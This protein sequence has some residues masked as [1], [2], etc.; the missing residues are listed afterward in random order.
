MRSSSRGRSGNPKGRPKKSATQE[1]ALQRVLAQQIPIVIDRKRKL[2][3]ADEAILHR[4]LIK[5]L[6][7]DLRAIKLF[8]DI[9]A[10]APPRDEQTDQIEEMSPD[11]DAVIARYL[12]RRRRDGWSPAGGADEQGGEDE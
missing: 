9:R 8:N 1:T 3:A 2:M 12:G 11:D 7:G 6:S 5:A 10:A 4:L